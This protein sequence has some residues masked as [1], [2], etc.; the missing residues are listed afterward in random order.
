MSDDRLI[1][2]TIVGTLAFVMISVV[3]VLL[4]GLFISSVDNN[5]VFEILGPAFQTTLGAFVGILTG[6]LLNRKSND[7][8][9]VDNGSTSKRQ[10]TAP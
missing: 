9:D 1:F 5:K 10:E 8:G 3:L 6:Q 7:S 2:R 4:A